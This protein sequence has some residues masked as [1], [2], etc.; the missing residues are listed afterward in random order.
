VRYYRI[1]LSNAQTGQPILPS[2]LGGLPI[3]SLLPGGGVNVA[4]LQIELDI[5]VAAQHSPAGQAL[6]R[7]WGLGLKDLGNA[8][9]LNGANISVSAGMSSGLPLAN[10]SQARLLVKGQILQAYGNWIGTEQTVDMI[11]TTPSGTTTSPANFVLNWQAG[12][13]L[14]DALS[15]TFSTALPKAKQNIN[16]SPRLKLSYDCVGYYETLVQFASWLNE[17]SKSVITDTG[18]LG[19]TIDYS[20]GI[21]I[22]VTDLTGPPSPVKAIAFQDLIGQPTWIGPLTIHAKCVMRGDI[23]LNDVVSLPQSLVT[24]TA[25]AM[26]NFTQSPANSLTF[27]GNY[28]VTDMHHYGNF[29]QPDAGSWN[30]TFNMVPQPKALAS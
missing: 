22:N 9:N 15:T 30:T 13:T 5:P 14:A 27:S 4:A 25:Q 6:V 12:T 11:L 20:D 29:R 23:N 28:V 19:V 16:I 21:T 7:V 1:D 3:S 8:F 17:F 10:P 24:T 18:Y 26:T 2:S